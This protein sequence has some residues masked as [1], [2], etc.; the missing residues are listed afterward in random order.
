[1]ITRVNGGKKSISTFISRNLYVTTDSVTEVVTM[2]VILGDLNSCCYGIRSDKVT[3]RKKQ[4]DVFRALID[5][6]KFIA[7]LDKSSIENKG[8]TW[9]K[10]FVAVVDYVDK[11]FE[12][13]QKNAAKKTPS[14]VTA[15]KAQSLSNMFK[16]FVRKANARGPKLK[17]KNVLR[18]IV[19]SLN[20]SLELFAVDY[21]SVLLKDVLLVPQMMTEISQQLWHELLDI[22]CRIYIGTCEGLDRVFLLTIIENI[23]VFGSKQTNFNAVHLIKFFN[24]GFYSLRKEQSH[25]HID[26]FVSAA[27]AFSYAFATEYRLQMCQLGE[28]VFSIIQDWLESRLSEGLKLSLVRFLEFQVSIHH[29]SGVSKSEKGAYTDDEIVWKKCLRK[30]YSFLLSDIISFTNRNK[31]DTSKTSQL[32][33]CYLNLFAQTC[34]LMP[35]ASGNELQSQDGGMLCSASKRQKKS[36]PIN[37]ILDEIQQNAETETCIV[38]LQ[39]LAHY[40]TLFPDSLNASLLKTVLSELHQLLIKCKK[41]SISEHILII[42]CTCVKSQECLEL[43]ENLSREETDFFKKMWKLIYDTSLRLFIL[44]Q[45]KDQCLKLIKLLIVQKLVKP[46]VELWSLFTAKQTLSDPLLQI[47]AFYLQHNEMPK[48]NPREILPPETDEQVFT[49]DYNSSYRLYLIHFIL[50]PLFNEDEIQSHYNSVNFNLLSQILVTLCLCSSLDFNLSKHYKPYWMNPSDRKDLKFIESFYLKSTFNAPFQQ[51]GKTQIEDVCVNIS[52]SPVIMEKLF[53][54]ILRDV[55][56]LL[57]SLKPELLNVQITCKYCCLVLCIIR[58]VLKLKVVTAVEINALE[59]YDK[60]KMLFDILTQSIETVSNTGSKLSVMESLL[61]LC[62]EGLDCNNEIFVRDLIPNRLLGFLFSILQNEMPN[63]NKA[64]E[65]GD[66]EFEADL[67]GEFETRSSFAEESTRDSQ[68]FK[69]D[70][71][72]PLN[73][74]MYNLCA[75]CLCVFN[76]FHVNQP[77]ADNNV[78]FNLVELFLNEKFDANI[79]SNLQL[80]MNTIRDIFCSKHVINDAIILQTTAVLRKISK[81]YYKHVDIAAGIFD[82]IA[83]LM[84]YLKHSSADV[85]ENTLNLLHSFWKQHK[86]RPMGAPATLAF[87]KC[88]KAIINVDPFNEWARWPVEGSNV[89]TIPISIHLVEMMELSSYVV[90]LEATDS[91]ANLVKVEKH[92]VTRGIAEWQNEILTKVCAIKEKW[93][94][95][96]LSVERNLAQVEAS[97]NEQCVFVM[98]LTNVSAVNSYCEKKTIFTLVVAILEDKILLEVVNKALERISNS[99]G[100]ASVKCYLEIHLEYLIFN[101]LKSKRHIF[102]FPFQLVDCIS[103]HTFA[104]EFYSVLVP[105]ILITGNQSMMVE[106]SNVLSRDVKTLIIECFPK[107]AVLIIPCLSVKNDKNLI[108]KVNTF[109]TLNQA[110]SCYDFLKKT[111]TTEGFNAL[112]KTSLDEIIVELLSALEIEAKNDTILPPNNP[113]SYLE[114]IIL[115]SCDYIN[116]QIDSSS[117]DRSIV[118]L[119]AK[120]YSIQNILLSLRLKVSVLRKHDRFQAFHAYKLFVKWVFKELGS[121][122]KLKFF[123]IRDVVHTLVYFI[124]EYPKEIKFASDAIRFLCEVSECILPISSQDLGNLLSFIVNSLLPLLFIKDLKLEISSLFEMLLVKNVD[125]LRDFIQALDPFPNIPELSEISDVHRRL[126][127]A[128]GDLTLTDEINCFLENCRSDTGKTTSSRLEGLRFLKRELCEQKSGLYGISQK[129]SEMPRFSEHCQRS[130]IHQLIAELIHLSSSSDTDVAIE[131]AR[132]LGEIGPIDLYSLVLQVDDG[133]KIYKQELQCFQNDTIGQRNAILL[134]LL[135]ENLFNKDVKLVKTTSSVVKTFL[136]TKSGRNFISQYEN[137][138]HDDVLFS[139]LNPFKTHKTAANCIEEF[140]LTEDSILN[141]LNDDIVWCPSNALEYDKWISNLVCDLI[142]GAT[143]DEILHS[144]IPIAKHQVTF[145][146]VIFP[147]V[148]Y[149]ILKESDERVGVLLSSKINDFFQIQC[150]HITNNGPTCKEAIKTMLSMINYL[151]LQGKPNKST[152]SQWD[153]N[154]WLNLNYLNV[155]RAAEYCNANFSA[156]MFLQIWSNS[157]IKQGTKS[158]ETNVEYSKTYN[159]AHILSEV[160]A[161]SEVY[162]LILKT[163]RNI[164]D[165]DGCYG[166]QIG[167]I[168]LPIKQIHEYEYELQWNQALAAYA[169]TADTNPT[170]QMGVLKSLQMLGNTHVLKS[171]LKE[172]NRNELANNEEFKEFEYECMWRLCQWNLP[173][174]SAG[175]TQFN[176]SVYNVVTDLV[177]SEESRFTSDVRNAYNCV[178]RNL[179][180]INLENTFSVYSALTQSQILVQL[181]DYKNA[182]NVSDEVLDAMN[183]KWTSNDRFGSSNFL[184]LEPVITN[185][186][187][188]S[189]INQC[190]ATDTQILGERL[191]LKSKLA[192][193][194]KY[195]DLAASTVHQAKILP[196]LNQKLIW[197]CEVEEARIYWERKESTTAIQKIRKLLSTFDKA[198]NNGA[199]SGLHSQALGLISKWLIETKSDIPNTIMQHLNDAITLSTQIEENS[200]MTDAYLAIARYSDSNYQQIT[201]HMESTEYDSKVKLITKSKEDADQL[202]KHAASM[203]IDQRKSVVF[204]EKQSRADEQEIIDMKENQKVYLIQALKGYLACLKNSATQDLRIFRVITLWFKNQ[205]NEEVNKLIHRLAVTNFSR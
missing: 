110:T 95:K 108:A 38:W 42:C 182:K 195:L 185:Q 72:L 196:N 87:I 14:K 22:M 127:Y 30:I 50:R 81:V 117:A 159:V 115:K 102:K 36:G 175:N 43:H 121:L 3:E 47:V 65:F 190:S 40:I 148:M 189:Q 104:V 113:P 99:L 49:D 25:T 150:Q 162:E 133:A 10:V 32:P 153:Q 202:K 76:Y 193:E 187:V 171:Y 169:H 21:C 203:N 93:K 26:A 12:H 46:D 105:W 173:R 106:I 85:Q 71:N 2:D 119:I 186:L 13:T 5:Q 82:L 122:E 109:I 141:T 147:F 112:L 97:L 15:R 60:I 118:V 128:K 8:L 58:L 68:T 96:S 20:K 23:I 78:Q 156:L 7:A 164:G 199:S 176:K 179:S 125:Q 168:D 178:I 86:K 35:Y 100:Y 28:S 88:I 146:Q 158:R 180:S 91:V 11:E 90:Q 184:F 52:A 55:R 163:Y 24:D 183:T 69:I 67:D 123:L 45:A 129:L 136:E 79:P 120:D 6:Q 63:E 101:W 135:S 66:D 77:T 191:L 64:T 177:Q 17:C 126:K 34:R 27:I 154:F 200:D 48:R 188:L 155:A 62:T 41:G 124:L 143:F 192:R 4:A 201:V 111:L 130:V 39:I 80:M 83:I 181:E 31:Y 205:N 74:T 174:E 59:V 165:A 167:E 152:T 142:D 151:R 161:S 194:A 92:E 16:F 84:P 94:S 144:V 44:N 160:S 198:E 29:P 9:E 170:Y 172:I 145:C 116:T 1:M 132:C 157:L 57:D 33:S 140:D 139:I 131:A 107:I 197:N 204:M 19:E 53:E 18:H 56:I 54:I 166:F 70:S 75:K 103:S 37:E 149:S 61:V 89:D 137:K 134:K 73:N 138:K 98:A 114:T 51:V